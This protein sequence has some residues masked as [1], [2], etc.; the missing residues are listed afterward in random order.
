[1]QSDIKSFE[2][3]LKRMNQYDNNSKDPIERVKGSIEAI[4][5]KT[6]I[7]DYDNV[8]ELLELFDEKIEQNKKQYINPTAFIFGFFVTTGNKIDKKKINEIFKKYNNELVNVELVDIIRY[9]RFWLKIKNPTDFEEEIEE[10][11][12]FNEEEENVFNY[13]DENNDDE[14]NEF[15]ENNYED[16]DYNGAAEYKFPGNW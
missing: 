13:I 3:T 16:D 12:N 10:S 6:E 2:R 8:Q 15:D 14:E 7:Y 9:A 4:C 1:M 11:K 5:L